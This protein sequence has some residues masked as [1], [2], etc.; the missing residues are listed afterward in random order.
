[1]ASEANILE[2]DG[3]ALSSGN[4]TLM[5]RERGKKGAN[6][7]KRKQRFGRSVKSVGRRAGVR[8]GGPGVGRGPVGRS[9]AAND[10]RPKA[11]RKLSNEQEKAKGNA[12]EI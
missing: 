10:G 3:G 1:M 8:R 12:Q 5:K 9:R 2:R 6:A 7:G 4:S 11:E